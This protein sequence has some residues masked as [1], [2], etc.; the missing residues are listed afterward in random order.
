[1]LGMLGMLGISGTCLHDFNPY[2]TLLIFIL[3]WESP[4]MTRLFNQVSLQ[5]VCL[6]LLGKKNKWQ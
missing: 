4:T 1:M 5:Q 6:K 2:R 3:P